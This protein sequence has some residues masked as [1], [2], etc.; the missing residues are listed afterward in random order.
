MGGRE[1]DSLREYISCVDS[2]MLS[3][4]VTLRT[5]IFMYNSTLGN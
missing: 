3:L 2:R 1:G 5:A 4:I